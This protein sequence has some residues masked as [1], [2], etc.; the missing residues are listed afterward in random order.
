MKGE[1]DRMSG[2]LFHWDRGRLARC[3]REARARQRKAKFQEDPVAPDSHRGG[4]DAR[5]PSGEV[6]LS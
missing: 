6:D 3:E 5:G 1:A 2:S 4:R